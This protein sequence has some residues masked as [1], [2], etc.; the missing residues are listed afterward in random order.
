MHQ[1]TRP[2]FGSGNGTSTIQHQAIV[3]TNVDLLLNGPLGTYSSEIWNKIQK[4]SFKK[5]HFK[6]LSAKWWP[7]VS[8]SMWYS[9][10]VSERTK[11]W[12]PI[13]FWVIGGLANSNQKHYIKFYKTKE[14]S[15]ICYKFPEQLKLTCVNCTQYAIY[16]LKYVDLS[17][18]HISQSV[19]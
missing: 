13:V 2:S 15:D 9:N 4:F 10:R 18:P 12:Q 11:G 6:M 19:L 5:M 3:W 7:F 17:H 14:D 1:W 8:A 16:T